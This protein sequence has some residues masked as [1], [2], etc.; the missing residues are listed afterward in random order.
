[1]IFLEVLLY[2]LLINYYVCLYLFL[3]FCNSNRLFYC[4]DSFFIS[5]LINILTACQHVNIFTS[6]LFCMQ[7]FSFSSVHD[8]TKMFTYPKNYLICQCNICFVSLFDFGIFLSRNRIMDIC[9]S[10]RMCACLVT[11]FETQALDLKCNRI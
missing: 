6:L 5:I 4:F 10:R 2:S 1:M 7:S 3:F 11:C 8:I 9:F